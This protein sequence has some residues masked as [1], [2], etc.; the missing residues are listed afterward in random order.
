M[1]KWFL[2]FC[3]CLS[4]GA[5][6]PQDNPGWSSPQFDQI[7]VLGLSYRTPLFYDLD[8]DFKLRLSVKE[9]FTFPT[10]TQFGFSYTQFQ[11]ALTEDGK[12]LR[13]FIPVEPEAKRITFK[14]RRLELGIGIGLFHQ[15][16]KLATNGLIGLQPYAGAYIEAKSMPE[17]QLSKKQFWKIP[18]DEEVWNKWGNGEARLYQVYGGITFY[19]GIN[20]SVITLA[21]AQA[22]QQGQYRIFL[23][24][25]NS[26]QLRVKLRLEQLKKKTFYT[27][28]ALFNA[29][30]DKIKFWD[31]EHTYIVQMDNEQEREALRNL[32]RGD[33]RELQMKEQEN[34]LPWMNHWI[35]KQRVIYYGVPWIAGKTKSKSQLERIDT[36]DKV[37]SVWVLSNYN[38]NNGLLL[39]SKTQ[40]FLVTY[41]PNEKM[42]YGVLSF[43]R[44]KLKTQKM[45]DVFFTWLS[46]LGVQQ[47]P[48]IKDTENLGYSLVN[49]S[50]RFPEEKLWK[51]L[52][53]VPKLTA[54]EYQAR[55]LELELN[56]QQSPRAESA[57]ITMS[58]LKQWLEEETETPYIPRVQI[59]RYLS[60]NPV[61]WSML[62]QKAQVSMEIHFNYL[63]EQFYP[64]E[65]RFLIPDGI[66]L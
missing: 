37:G 30:F 20:F 44:R 25:I 66:E 61:L 19:T 35:G 22:T 4:V 53:N 39:T 58:E 28:F 33:I 45:K 55:C 7:N 3:T 9:S 42:I 18:L 43:E 52:S 23:E 10:L 34:N 14:R 11:F 2:I 40:R 50:F 26:K 63:G 16:L 12:P 60:R 6:T 29:Q 32:W 1:L 54:A 59:I 57:M 46:R 64:V 13:E 38:I 48:K 56:C 27:G 5:Q 65:K 51:I 21:Q 47:L 15:S 8:G 31:R 36:G 41:V 24:K 17:T 49:L 62:A